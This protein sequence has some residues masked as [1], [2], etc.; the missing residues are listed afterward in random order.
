MPAFLKLSR[1]VVSVLFVGINCLN[2]SLVFADEL[3]EKRIHSILKDNCFGCH[4][5]G[6]A[7]G[8]LSF[9]SVATKDLIVDKKLWWNVLKNVR[10]GLM[11]PASE[12][13]LSLDDRSTLLNWI[14]TS[15]FEL[16]STNPDPG[17]VT[18]RRLNRQ[19]YH[20]TI[21]DLM[22][23]DF[24][25][26]VVFPP[27]DTGFGFD[28]NGD[29][30]SLS[31]ILL[32][33]YLA[34]A[35]T[36]VQEAVPTVTFVRPVQSI[37]GGQFRSK[38]SS[39]TGRRLDAKEEN[40]VLSSVKVEDEGM[41]NVK[42][43]VRLHGSFFFNPARCKV[44]FY[45]DDEQ[46]Y[47]DEYGWD[48]NKKLNYEFARRLTVGEHLLRFEITPVAPAQ[49]A[50]D[51]A[52]EDPEDDTFVYWN[53]DHVEIEGPIDSNKWVHPENYD[54]FF[55]CIEPP[56][57]ADERREYARRV[58][59][60]FAS[61]AFRRPVADATIDKLV[62]IAQAAE[63][64]P[65]AT[66]ESSV[67]QAMTAVLA[68]PRFLF[69][70]EETQ[71]SS[72]PYP[73]IDE[74]SLASRLSYFLW[75]TMPDQELFDLAAAGQ[76]R[77]SLPAQIERMMKDKRSD[78]FVQ[79][80]VGQWLR[81]RDIEHVSID[82]IVVMGLKKE[83]DELRE[84]FRR[85]FSRDPSVP[86]LSEEEAKVV[87][88]RFR[89]L[90]NIG[91]KFDSDTRAAMQAE[92]QM[93]F[94]HVVREDR[95]VLDLIDSN[96]TFVNEKLAELYGIE[97]VAGEEM[98]R[99][100]LPAGS[101]RGGVLTQGT[102][103]VVTSN[104]TRTSPVKRG[105]F[106]LENILGLPAPPAPANVP[107]LEASAEKF[108]GR[109]PPLRELLAAH[110]ES[111]L[112]ASCHARMDPLGLAL[113]NFNAIGMWRD[114]EQ[115]LPVDASGTL[116]TGESFRDIRELKKILR[117]E[118]RA[119]FYRCMTQKLLIYALG[120]GLDYPDE[121]IVDDIVAELE[122]ADGKFSVMLSKVVQS[123]AFQRQRRV[124]HLESLA[125]QGK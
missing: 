114:N 37:G 60:R 12:P 118:H 23:I 111:A 105:L 47:E 66:F 39:V 104:P 57:D 36:I 15:A 125:S 86:Q 91:D 68:S 80:F 43:Q 94:E 10:A 78:Q 115:G 76:L 20:N 52:G 56:K 90:R 88:E 38:S 99:V 69:R 110:R 98:R 40:V 73:F 22:G 92:T 121:V 35:R 108:A 16:D 54:R 74:F 101:P 8:N 63:A 13:K 70:L 89:E 65:G 58:L 46:L 103:L 102:M 113:E 107:E 64:V 33:K 34:S 97:G 53:I 21:R 49:N 31:P 109:E 6:A 124:S 100:E 5:N 25:A 51:N 1:L 61:K 7:E 26:D 119:D 19:E 81:S 48:E 87:R 3:F 32:E 30:L 9:D 72:D 42:V 62:K 79:N 45:C 116:A 117:E 50:G 17:K 28:N 4:A 44:R 59:S 120:R 11:P 71:E 106:I 96:Y 14:K 67:S 29:V 123:A 85:R 93:L 77:S 122:Q 83:F 55:D 95:S 84:K 27:D 41:Y 82:P 24:N 112:C 75:S 2:A 18:A